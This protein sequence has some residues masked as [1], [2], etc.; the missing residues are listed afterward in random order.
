MGLSIRMESR[1]LTR[2]AKAQLKLSRSLPS[3]L[4]IS[5]R[6]IWPWPI[7]RTVIP[8]KWHNGVK[9]IT[10]HGMNARI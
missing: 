4:I 1:I 9:T 6:L 10:I 2:L 7:K 5:I 3:V 8:K